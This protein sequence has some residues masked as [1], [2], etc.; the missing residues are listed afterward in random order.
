MCFVLFLFEQVFVMIDLEKIFPTQRES[1]QS[2]QE[3]E[4]YEDSKFM[5]LRY[6]CGGYEVKLWGDSIWSWD[7]WGLGKFVTLL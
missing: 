2:E 7:L 1:L 3:R 6:N 5:S 4:S